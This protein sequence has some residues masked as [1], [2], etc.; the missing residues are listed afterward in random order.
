MV[1]Q[2]GAELAAIRQYDGYFASIHVLPDWQPGELVVA[3]TPDAWV[4]FLAGQYH[5][6]DALN[7]QYGPVQV[8]IYGAFALHLTFS[9][10]YHPVLLGGIYS[11]ADGVQYAEPRIL[12]GDGNDIV[13]PALGSYTF[14]HGWGDC[15]AGCAFRHYWDFTVT[16]G[17]AQLVSEHGDPFGACCLADHTCVLAIRQE[18]EYQGFEGLYGTFHGGHC[19]PS[20]CGTTAAAE[21]GEG[22]GWG[23]MKSLYR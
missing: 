23:R 12:Y 17:V 8:E 15:I 4:L 22:V 7:A 20:P 21:P 2:I 9:R 14:K 10:A 1:T 5:G 3:L 11:A 18:C 13:A 6:L 16:D 19:V